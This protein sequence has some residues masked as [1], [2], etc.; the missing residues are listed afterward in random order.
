MNTLQSQQQSQTMSQ[1][2]LYPVK[3]L[4]TL[5]IVSVVLNVFFL[6]LYLLQA[7]QKYR[8]YWQLEPLRQKLRIAKQEAALG[9]IPQTDGNCH[10]CHQPLQLGAEFCVYCRERVVEQPRICPV[11]YARTLPDA[12]WCPECGTQLDTTV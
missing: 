2:H 3:L 5:A 4:A 7:Y 1:R 8:Y 12:R 11:C 9:M 10:K 6:G